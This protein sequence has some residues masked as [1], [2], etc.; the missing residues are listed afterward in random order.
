M[1]AR[2]F[3]LAVSAMI[4]AEP[5]LAAPRRRPRNVPEIDLFSG[6]AALM[7]LATLALLLWERHRRLLR[8]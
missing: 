8:H 1:L 4:W 5:V 3:V 6:A 7:I 2:L